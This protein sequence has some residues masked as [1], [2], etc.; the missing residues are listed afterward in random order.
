MSTEQARTRTV[1]Y[2]RVSTRK[3]ADDG[4]S[5]DAQLERIRAYAALYNL[6]LVGDLVV[7]A[8]ASADSLKRP[9][10]Q[11][12]LAVLDEGRADALLVTKLDR[13]TRSVTD[14]AHLLTHYFAEGRFALMSVT[15]QLDTRTANGR[16][17]LGL[18]TQVAQ[19]ER[20]S[21]SERTKA[22]MKMKRERGEFLGGLVPYGWAVEGTKLVPHD[23]EQIT[24]ALAQELR[25]G[26]SLRTVAAELAARDRLSRSGK[27]FTASSLRRI[28][29]EDREPATK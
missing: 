2:V 22:V 25:D 4:Q 6:E 21:V 26:R 5:L 13:L 8:G 14:L 12:A 24:L 18:L 9:G 20:E 27:P 29:G 1:A 16:L 15:D 7:D 28:L 23:E 3:Q 10:L 17:V 19:W 11:R